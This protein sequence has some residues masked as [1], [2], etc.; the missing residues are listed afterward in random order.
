MNSM[1]AKGRFACI[2]IKSR[3]EYICCIF[4]HIVKGSPATDV[5]GEFS[6]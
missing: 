5:D 6:M 1:Y 3:R 2:C 4:I